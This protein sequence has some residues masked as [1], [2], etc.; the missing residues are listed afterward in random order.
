MAQ[1]LGNEVTTVSTHAGEVRVRDT[2]GPGR[3]VLLVHSLLLDGGLYSRLVPLLVAQGRRCIVPDLPLG[4]HSPAMHADADLSPAGLARLLADVLDRRGVEV[5][6][7]VGV[8]TGGALTQ[9]L[10][11]DHRDRVG[12]VV[13]TACD[14][15]EEFPPKSFAWAAKG[16]KIP[17]SLWLTAALLRLRPQAYSLKMFTHRGAGVELGRQWAA[18][19]A[20]AGVRRDVAKAIAGMRGSVTLA[21]AE[22]NRDF[23]RPVVVAWGDDDRVFPSSLGDRLAADIPGARLVTLDDCAAFAA[24]DRPETLAELV[25]TVAA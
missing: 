8:D 22:A 3:P 10:M 23:P 13:L 6:D 7:V 12:S 5:A 20:D 19:M 15:Y 16:L 11:A 17:G 9:L 21:A 24:L 18:P 1:P 2:G 25:A 14:A 4:A